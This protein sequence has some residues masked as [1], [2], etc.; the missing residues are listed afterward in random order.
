MSALWVKGR[1]ASA[2]RVAHSIIYHASCVY[3]SRA[4]LYLLA[5]NSKKVQKNSLVAVVGVGRLTKKVVHL[6]KCTSTQ[7]VHVIKEKSIGKGITL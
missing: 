2:L 1:V 3:F 4:F 7:K 5:K 6:K